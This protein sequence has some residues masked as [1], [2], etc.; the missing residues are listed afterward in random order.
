EGGL[1]GTPISAYAIIKNNASAKEA[2]SANSDFPVRFLA[3]KNAII[4]GI[5]IY[6]AKTEE[7]DTPFCMIRI[8][9]ILAIISIAP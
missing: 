5:S 7:A 8:T 4:G 2:I 3:L 6:L 1:G 9:N